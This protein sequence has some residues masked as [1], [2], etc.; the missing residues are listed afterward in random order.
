MHTNNNNKLIII[1]H[2]I[3]DILNYSSDSVISPPQCHL[4]HH[5]MWYAHFSFTC[6]HAHAQ[7]AVEPSYIL[8]SVG[9]WVHNKITIQ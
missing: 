4:S 6:M 5:L 3:N 8:D 7:G 2:V 1:N 9:K